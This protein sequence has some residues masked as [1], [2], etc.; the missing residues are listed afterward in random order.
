MRW[1]PPRR[2]ADLLGGPPGGM[3]ARLRPEP[4]KSAHQLA[5]VEQ[6]DMLV[7][8][9]GGRRWNMGEEGGL[10]DRRRR[11]EARRGKSRR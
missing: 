8:G 2:G 1:V 4:P 9:A 10:E 6:A 3:R 11:R 5:R 7:C